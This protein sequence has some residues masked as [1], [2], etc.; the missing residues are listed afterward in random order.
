MSLA[1]GTAI[2][3]L[4][5]EITAVFHSHVGWRVGRSLRG[6]V[7]GGRSLYSGRMKEGGAERG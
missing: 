5:G 1:L 4:A 3:A 7:G 6:R 2:N